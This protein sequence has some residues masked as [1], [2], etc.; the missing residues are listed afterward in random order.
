MREPRI[1]PLSPDEFPD[2]VT[3]TLSALQ[4]PDGQVLNIFA[5]FARHPRLF[6]RWL[7]LGGQLLQGSELPARDRELLILRCGW[8][9]R[10]DYEWGQHV[11]IA[12]EVGL[13]DSEIARVPAGPQAD[14]WEPF[15]ATLLRAAD[16]LHGEA[17]ISDATWE[18]LKVRYD[19]HQM[20]EVPMLVGHY[21][22]VAYTLNSLGVQRE[23]GVVALPSRDV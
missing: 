11:R 15:D 18:E 12:G 13:T 2:S 8:N 5:T 4:G 20:I 1:P 10:S 6:K 9:C 7:P 21:H 16:E 22:L 3:G 23:P 14:G 19:E 17:R